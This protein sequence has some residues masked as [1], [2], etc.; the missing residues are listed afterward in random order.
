MATLW[1]L[2]GTTVLAMADV[3]GAYEP[4]AAVPCDILKAAHHGS[5]D[6]TGA[7]FAQTADPTAVLLSARKREHLVSLTERLPSAAVWATGT[8]G[9]LIVDFTETGFTI[10]PF[11]AREETE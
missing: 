11:W 7:A 10:T 9:A 5:E 6:S 2:R 1:T 3:T 4:Y 8:Q